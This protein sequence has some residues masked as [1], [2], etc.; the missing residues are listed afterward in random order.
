MKEQFHRLI[1]GR[2]PIERTEWGNIYRAEFTLNG[3]RRLWNIEV[4]DIPESRNNKNVPWKKEGS[5]DKELSGNTENELERYLALFRRIDAVKEEKEDSAVVCPEAIYYEKLRRKTRVYLVYEPMEHIITENDPYIDSESF[6]KILLDLVRLERR[7]REAGLELP[8]FGP[9]NL[10]LCENGKVKIKPGKTENNAP[11]SLKALFEL[12]FP[13]MEM[14][15]FQEETDEYPGEVSNALEEKITELLDEIRLG[16][17]EIEY[18]TFPFLSQSN[19]IRKEVHPAFIRGSKRKTFGTVII[20]V[21]F[22]SLLIQFKRERKEVSEE[23]NVSVPVVIEE[24]IPET[25]KPSEEPFPSRTS[26]ETGVY[27]YEG[28][29]V[30]YEGII[31]EEYYLDPEGNIRT[32]DG[33]AYLKKENVEEY[34][35]A[36]EMF[37][38]KA[39]VIYEVLTEEMPLEITIEYTVKATNITNPNLCAEVLSG[40][41]F[42]TESNEKTMNL[43]IENR[44]QFVS[45]TVPEE[46]ISELR[47]MDC[48]GQFRDTMTVRVVIKEPISTPA[49]NTG[50]TTSY[51]TVP[52]QTYPVLT[53]APEITIPVSDEFTVTPER[54]SLTVGETCPLELSHSASFRS[55]D[56]SVATVNED[57]VIAANGE[58]QCILTVTCMEKE[59]PYLEKIEIPITVNG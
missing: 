30:S 49:V 48:S 53:P 46:G 20:C 4:A 12:V 34:R 15:E 56:S 32:A 14:N 3:I 5:I 38:R 8:G 22:L 51:A 23:N 29:C 44:E 43:S 54:I 26:K 10:F 27:L 41:A 18:M 16:Q 42:F 31:L 40:E 17:R 39:S 19:E 25:P 6:G 24:T 59:G 21:L 1:D 47:I 28:L 45:I 50:N 52:A 36:E 55:S 2:I 11:E 37:F 35:Y 57:G 13:Y 9:E 7:Y 33:K 58:G